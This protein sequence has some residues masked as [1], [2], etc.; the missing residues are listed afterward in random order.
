[1]SGRCTNSNHVKAADGTC[2]VGR[3]FVHEVPPELEW[4]TNPGWERSPSRPVT[5][6]PPG[7]PVATDAMPFGLC[8]VT[9]CGKVA[10]TRTPRIRGLTAV[11]VSGQRT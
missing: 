6:V 1:M 5:C 8:D 7:Q 4:P 9:G 3:L 11:E 2:L 10:G